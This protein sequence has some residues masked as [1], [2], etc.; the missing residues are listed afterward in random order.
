MNIPVVWFPERISCSAAAMLNEMLDSVEVEHCVMPTLPLEANGAVIVFHGQN[1]SSCSQ[2]ANVAERLNKYAAPLS[3]VIF[4]S[5]GDEACEFPYHLLYHPNHRLWLQ[6]PKP[7]KAEAS[8]YMIEGYPAGIHQKLP[9]EN[10][11]PLDWMFAGQVTH[12]RRKEFVHALSSVPVDYKNIFLATDT[13]GSGFAHEDYYRYMRQAKVVP[14]PSGPATPDSFRFAEALEA[15]CVPI[16]DAYSPDH[17]P[18]YWDL[19]LGKHPFSVIEDW[20]TL[21]QVMA[22]ILGDFERRQ[23]EANYWWRNYKIKFR[24]TWLARDLIDLGAL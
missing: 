14:C 3:W 24:S 19:V 22:E 21:P 4:I 7:G 20:S 10:G 18:G 5:V 13:F 12:S 2:G 9:A 16:L 6:T 15:G 11:R 1:Q 8:R 23:R 17:V